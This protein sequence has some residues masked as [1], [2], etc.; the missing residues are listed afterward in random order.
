MKAGPQN[1]SARCFF[2]AI[3]SPPNVS[4]QIAAV[5]PPVSQHSTLHVCVPKSDLDRLGFNKPKFA[6]L[7]VL[8]L[9]KRNLTMRCS[10]I[11]AH[12]AAEDQHRVK[13][14]RLWLVV[15]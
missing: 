9:R 15:C 2:K 4:S 11:P 8:P 13:P 10:R 12:V 6:M 3:S 5:R 14:P 7:M 1:G